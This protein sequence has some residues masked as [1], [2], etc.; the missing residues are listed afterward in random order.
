MGL[1]D[2]YNKFHRASSIQ[3]KVINEK[4]FTYRIVLSVIDEKIRGRKNLHILDFGCGVGAVSL[5]LAKC[6]HKVTGVDVSDKAIKIANKS[7]KLLK[8][9]RLKFYTLKSG[10][11]K[12]NNKKFDLI[13]C[14]EVIEH[15][16]EDLELLIFLTKRL[17]KGGIFIIST[18]SINAPLYRLGL[19]K[20]F[21]SKVGHLRRYDAIHLAGMIKKT[22]LE[23]EKILKKEG[24]VRNSL[25]LFPLFGKLV[26]F[27]RGPISDFVS[28]IDDSTVP[29]FGES[30]I[31]VVS[32]K[33]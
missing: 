20:S 22:G 28:I 29:L 31:F 12:I 25:F 2:F 16:K 19:A 9:D 6:G 27:V 10:K 30:D 1:I 11:K 24:I 23:I 17:K 21:D 5:F 15:I 14:I 32:R 13:I 26:R 4:N 7:A 3:K 33:P 18:P 8:I